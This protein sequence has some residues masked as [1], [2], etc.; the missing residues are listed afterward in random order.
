MRKTFTLMRA[1]D[2]DRRHLLRGA[3]AAAGSALLAGCDRL[4][5]NASFTGTLQSAEHLNRTIAKVVAPRPAILAI[6]RFRCSALCSVSVNDA[7]RDSRSQPARN[8][9]PAAATAPRNRCLRSRSRA[10]FRVNVFFTAAPPSWHGP[11]RS[12]TS[13]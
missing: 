4:S 10:R 7:L 5:R 9:D 6:E 8:A 11:R 2:R 12:C 3:V 1:R 13:P